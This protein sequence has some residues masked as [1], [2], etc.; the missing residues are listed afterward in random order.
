M[1]KI[2]SIFILIV[3]FLEH[4]DL[5]KL[6]FVCKS[7]Y[8]QINFDP[9]LSKYLENCKKVMLD[10]LSIK[11]IIYQPKSICM[12]AIRQNAHALRYI[13]NQT[14][15]MCY[16]AIRKDERV[17]KF[18][19]KQNTYVNNFTVP[20]EIFDIISSYLNCYDKARL[21]LVCKSL[22]LQTNFIGLLYIHKQIVYDLKLI[23][24]N[25]YSLKCVK[26]QTEQICL[27]AVRQRG[28]LLRDVKNQTEQ[29]CLEAVKQDSSAL[30]YVENQTEQICLEAVKQ[31]GSSLQYV[32]NQTEQICLEAVKQDSWALLYV[33]NQTE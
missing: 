15:Q 6:K 11:D 7:L 12:L 21:G 22:F 8:L 31:D 18:I 27:E 14:F 20:H 32:K 24:K 28:Y 16:H 29:I 17:F 25:C 33:K 26:N 5:V 30:Q 9:S 4:S 2:Q 10:G 1:S 19:K 23:K 3:P 13:K